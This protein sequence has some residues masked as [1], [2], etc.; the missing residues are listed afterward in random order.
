M[1]IKDRSRYPPDWPDISRTIR[2]R[3]GDCCEGSPA[4]PDCRAR[5]GDPHPVTGSRVVLTVA[6]LDHDPG[7]CDPSNLRAWCQRCHTTYDG[8]HHARTRKRTRSLKRHYQQ[9]ALFEWQESAEPPRPDRRV[10]Q[11]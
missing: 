3:A 4:Y 5:N 7:H 2:A 1:P 10:A 6:H 9:P 8:P 11:Q